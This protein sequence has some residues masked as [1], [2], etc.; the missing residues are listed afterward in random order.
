MATRKH[1]NLSTTV[2]A[3]MFGEH[4]RQGARSLRAGKETCLAAAQARPHRLTFDSIVAPLRLCVRFPFHLLALFVIFCALSWPS[5]ATAAPFSFDDIDYWVGDGANRA[6]LAIDWSHASTDPP[7]LV[8]GYRW[9]GAARGIDMLMAILQ[10]DTR[11][12]AK[13]GMDADYGNS[14]FGAG[15]DANNDGLFALEDETLF[16]EFGIALTSPIYGTTSAVDPADLYAQGWFTPQY[17]LYGT[18]TGNPYDGGSWSWSGAGAGSRVLDNGDWDSWTYAPVN[19]ITDFAENP[20]AAPAPGS[21][22]LPG[23]YNGNGMIDAADYIVWRDAM[24]LGLSTLPNRNSEISGLVGDEDFNYWRDHFGDSL[25]SGAT[26]SA[27]GAAIVPEPA[28]WHLA[29][30]ALWTLWLTAFRPRK[31]HD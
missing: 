10:A 14:L 8:W 21:G 16:D 29:M 3:T 28:A 26:G 13:L 18:S 4:P 20:Q 23:D 24:T 19:S 12:Y 2:L 11:L 30:I 7:A 5:S 15:Y 25:G 31:E 9:D 22:G 1:K 17:W 27:S 6:A